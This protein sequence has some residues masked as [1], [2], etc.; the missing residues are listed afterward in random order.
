MSLLRDESYI[1]DMSCGQSEIRLILNKKKNPEVLH[2]ISVAKPEDAKHTCFFL[3]FKK[4]ALLKH[5]F[6][7]RVRAFIFDNKKLE[8]EAE[9]NRCWGRAGC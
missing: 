6:F 1:R 8:R 3:F 5:D 4:G 7:R 9:G 2:P